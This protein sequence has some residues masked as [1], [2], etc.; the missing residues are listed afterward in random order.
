MNEGVERLM[1]YLR[2]IVLLGA[3]AAVVV[4]VL[5]TDSPSP[6]YPFGRAIDLLPQVG[7]LVGL[8]AWIVFMVRNKK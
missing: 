5:L 6:A 1:R 7:V 4:A 2:L 3:L 8:I